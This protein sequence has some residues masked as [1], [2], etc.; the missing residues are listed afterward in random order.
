MMIITK[1][2]HMLKSHIFWG[3]LL[4]KIMTFDYDGHDDDDDGD[5]DYSNED[6]GYDGDDDMDFNDDNLTI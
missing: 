5:D 2:V 6:E 1:C 4:M 3:P